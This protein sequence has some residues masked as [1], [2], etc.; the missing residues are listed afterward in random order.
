MLVDRV[1]EI[2]GP[3]RIQLP[4]LLASDA[5]VEFQA[6]LSGPTEGLQGGTSP[7][8]IDPCIL[9]CASLSLTCVSVGSIHS[10]VA[11]GAS[12]NWLQQHAGLIPAQSVEHLPEPH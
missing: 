2:S 8:C 6:L 4:R 11:L 3:V 10:G 12:V 1:V 9:R 5:L 7:S